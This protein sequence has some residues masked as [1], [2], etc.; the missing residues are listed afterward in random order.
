MKLRSFLPACLLLLI[1][2][3]A[4]AAPYPRYIQR[5]IANGTMS[6]EE[7][8]MLVENGL[9]SRPPAPQ[10]TRITYSG[11]VYDSLAA[12]Q[13]ESAYNQ[14]VNEARY[15]G[16]I[17]QRDERYYGRNYPVYGR[18]YRGCFSGLCRTPIYRL[19]TNNNVPVTGN[20]FALPPVRTFSP[21]VPAR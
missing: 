16:D 15:F 2:V 10:P 14:Q 11:V 7:A 3:P 6:I 9:G 20:A 18:F 1:A 8:N 19:P 21:F 12:A 17:Q 4:V 5:Q 13:A